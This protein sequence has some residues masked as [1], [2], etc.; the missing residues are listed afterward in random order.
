MVSDIMKPGHIN[1]LSLSQLLV[2]NHMEEA[3]FVDTD[4]EPE[5]EK[6]K[7]AKEIIEV[8]SDLF[9]RKY[10]TLKSKD[11]FGD[12]INYRPKYVSIKRLFGSIP[13]KTFHTNKENLYQYFKANTFEEKI[14]ILQRFYTRSQSLHEMNLTKVKLYTFY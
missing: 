1:N 6:P 10:R 5:E 9:E 11:D 8:Y 13:K 2:E 3:I 14:E 4:E 12:N 7:L